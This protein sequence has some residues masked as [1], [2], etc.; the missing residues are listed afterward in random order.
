M[1][2][3]TVCGLR[4]HTGLLDLIFYS[5]SQHTTKQS[6]ATDPC[7]L[8]VASE[9]CVGSADGGNCVISCCNSILCVIIA[10]LVLAKNIQIEIKY[11]FYLQGAY[12]VNFM[13]T[14][15]HLMI[16]RDRQ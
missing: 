5:V 12:S 14:K 6:A 11:N 15:V 8:N 9:R 2:A 16:K 7:N 1:C 4:G 10:H 3:H 13:L